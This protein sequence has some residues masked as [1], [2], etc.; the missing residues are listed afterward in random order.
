[1]NAPDDPGA[2]NLSLASQK[3]SNATSA[4]FQRIVQNHMRAEM[5]PRRLRTSTLHLRKEV[6][7]LCGSVVG[8]WPPEGPVTQAEYI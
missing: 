6:N 4:L 1:V 8:T 3:K 5:I 2:T 7:V